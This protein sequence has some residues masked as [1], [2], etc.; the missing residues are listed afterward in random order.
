M[1]SYWSNPFTKLYLGMQDADG[2][3]KWLSITQ[4][5]ISLHALLA[6]NSHTTTK[7]DKATWKSLLSGSSLQP[8]CNMQGFNVVSPSGTQ[9]PAITK[10]GIISNNE[11]DCH[12]CNS[13]IG[14]GCAGTRGKQDGSNSCG[15]EK[16]SEKHIK[17]NCYILVQ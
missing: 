13:R 8:N 10:I 5:A 11:D 4:Q 2:N 17:A 15:N 3:T 12:S 9:D 16:L 6:N 14:F 1:P 7:I